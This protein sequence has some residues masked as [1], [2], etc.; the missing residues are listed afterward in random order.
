LLIILS[1]KHAH[2]VIRRVHCT[3][4]KKRKKRRKDRRKR[5][6]YKMR[7]EETGMTNNY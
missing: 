1:D 7:K 2:M 6:H 5:E 4:S 3:D